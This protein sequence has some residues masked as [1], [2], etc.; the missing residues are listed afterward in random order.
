MNIN[1]S[2]YAIECLSNPEESNKLVFDVRID[3]EWYSTVFKD[4]K[5]VSIEKSTTEGTL[6][7]IKQNK[8]DWWDV[9][10]EIES[11]VNSAV[12]QWYKENNLYIPKLNTTSR[13]SMLGEFDLNT[14]KIEVINLSKVNLMIIHLLSLVYRDKHEEMIACINV[15]VKKIKS[16]KGSIRVDLLFNGIDNRINFNLNKMK[17]KYISNE[18]LIEENSL[19]RSFKELILERLDSN[20]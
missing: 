14:P 19:L 11:F 17:D 16:N 20:I 13:I 4:G 1:K 8:L 5:M 3:S 15:Y 9:D 6:E 18:V 7:Q 2:N 12:L 10:E